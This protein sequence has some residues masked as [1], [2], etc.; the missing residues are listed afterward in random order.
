MYFSALSRGFIKKKK[1]AEKLKTKRTIIDGIH[2][3]GYNIS[4]CQLGDCMSSVF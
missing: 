1:H 3:K 4:P 2:E